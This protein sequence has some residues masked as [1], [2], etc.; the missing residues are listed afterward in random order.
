MTVLGGCGT[1]P[2][3]EL[4]CSGYI[5]EHEGFRLLVDPGCATLPRLLRRLTVDAVDAV[6]LSHCHP[7][8]CADLNP[9]LRARGLSNEP[10]TPLPVH[11]PHKA[12]D[13]V[14]ALDRPGMLAAAYRLHEFHPSDLLRIVPFTVDTRRL[15]HF[16][17]QRRPP[18]QHSGGRAHLHR[19]HRSKRGHPGPGRRRGSSP[20]RGDVRPSGPVNR[21]RP[22]LPTARLAGR[23]TRQ[24]GEKQ[25]LLTHLWP[26][27][28][29]AAALR[30][31]A[32][33]GPTDIA[34][35]YLVVHL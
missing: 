15:P 12:L 5:V 34:A 25:L 17:P 8:H 1:W 13:A 19:R 14:L 23:H 26:G 6:L 4:A 18:D 29:P 11:A 35:P 16:V 28:D 22:C 3:G 9:L 20:V 21:R 33:A 2:T 27:T 24:A 10:P 30:A 32:F 31:A 7:D